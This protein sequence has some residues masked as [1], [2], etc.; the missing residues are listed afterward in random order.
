[1]TDPSHRIGAARAGRS[2]NAESCWICRRTG[3]GPVSFARPVLLALAL[4]A[5]NGEVPRRDAGLDGVED[6]ALE[7]S[8]AVNRASQIATR[9]LLVR[10]EPDIEPGAWYEDVI[11]T[12]TR[13][14]GGIGSMVRAELGPGPFWDADSLAAT[15]VARVRTALAAQA[16]AQDVWTGA[17]TVDSAL[18]AEMFRLA[19]AAWDNTVAAAE[20]SAVAWE[21]LSSGVGAV[22]L[23][24]LSATRADVDEFLSAWENVVDAAEAMWAVWDTV[25]TSQDSAALAV[26][27]AVKAA[28]ADY[29]YRLS[30]EALDSARNALVDLVGEWEVFLA[31]GGE[32]RAAALWSAISWQRGLT[33]GAALN[34]RIA[35]QQAAWESSTAYAAWEAADSVSG[36]AGTALNAADA[37]LDNSKSREL[38]VLGAMAAREAVDAAHAA[39]EAW[40]AVSTSVRQPE[41]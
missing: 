40:A 38:T 27:D 20:A 31:E 11:R 8:A 17:D 37:A 2:M 12:S 1:M 30:Q 32:G 16:N 21:A 4:A 7:A 41:S 39:A 23:A 36:A 9:A 19:D 13:G 34:A 25:T 29:S 5:C 33:D 18:A 28:M 6:A 15:V 3:W 24:S 35:A 14:P 10:V 26:E 22:D